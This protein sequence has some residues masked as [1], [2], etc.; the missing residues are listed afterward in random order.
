[1]RALQKRKVIHFRKD[2]FSSGIAT[3]SLRM[4]IVRQGVNAQW[5]GK[6]R[7]SSSGF[8]VFRGFEGVSC[9]SPISPVALWN[10]KVPKPEGN[11]GDG[12]F[13]G[14][15]LFPT[16]T[17]N[18]GGSSVVHHY[19][20]DLLMITEAMNEDRAYDHTGYFVGAEMSASRRNPVCTERCKSWHFKG[21]PYEKA[22]LFLCFEEAA[23]NP[24][25]KQ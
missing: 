19:G 15:A 8:I 13:V 22:S 9:R 11:Y 23:L 16:I 17:A 18:F 20:L 24:Q 12:I 21:I 7:F 2:S 25:I 4:R 10:I 14:V 5:S 1:M 6:A 3:C